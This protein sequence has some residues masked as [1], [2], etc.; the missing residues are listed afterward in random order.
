MTIAILFPL[1]NVLDLDPLSLGTLR[2]GSVRTKALIPV[3]PICC[4]ISCGLR[5]LSGLVYPI[6]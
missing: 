6:S 3:I 2:Y 1:K 5:D 4:V